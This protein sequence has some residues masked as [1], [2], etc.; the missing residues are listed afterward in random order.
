MANLS[1]DSSNP[2]VA[3]V[4]GKQTGATGSGVEGASDT[5]WGVYGHSKTG[6]GVV[7]SSEK[8]Y[9]LRA[10]S[11]DSAGLRAS[12]ENGRGLEGWSTKAEGVVGISVSGS[13][14]LGTSKTSGNGGWFESA[15]GEGVRGWSQNVNHGGVVGVNTGGGVAVYGTSDNGRGI[16]GWSIDSYGIAGESKNAAGVRGT[17]AISA[18]VEGWSKSGVGVWGVSDVH[19]G[20]HAETHSTVTAA[21][22]A[23]QMN[24]TSDSPA[25]FAKHM[26]GRVAAVFEGDVIVT[27]DISLANA[28]DCAEDFDVCVDASSEPGT[29]MAIDDLGELR[30]SDRANDRRVAGVV[31]G[32]GSYKPG[33]VLDRQAPAGHRRPIALLGKV[34]CKV[35]AEFGAIAVGDLLTTSPTPGHAMRVD[36]PLRAVGSVIGKALR[37]HADGRGLIPIL[38]ALQ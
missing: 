18:G 32:A 7:A 34:F 13:G 22:A 21:M 20:V 31:S 23:F 30:E 15:Q 2:S 27:G 37:P 10:S 4:L 12:S 38:I 14:V 11:V 36:D 16:E 26:G 35:D 17:S 24:A 1:G 9:G 6:R 8:D 25:L 19:E 5:G 33:V 28:A 29:V 3:A